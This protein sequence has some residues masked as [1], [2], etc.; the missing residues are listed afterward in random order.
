M[1]TNGFPNLF[2]SGGF[3]QS[4]FNAST[5][6]MMNRHAYHVAHIISAASAMNAIA[7]EPSK[8]AQDGWVKHVHETAIDQSQYTRECTPSYFNAEGNEKGQHYLGDTYGPGW[9]AFEAVL[10][11]WRSNGG[12][13]GMEIRQC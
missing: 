5:T 1:S 11:D 6:E 10:D 2:F 8:A 4:A 12:L 7:V 9:D 13:P 3:L